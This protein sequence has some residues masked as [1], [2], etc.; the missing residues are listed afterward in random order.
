LGLSENSQRW[1]HVAFNEVPKQWASE[2][3]N[4]KNNEYFIALRRNFTESGMVNELVVN[5]ASFSAP[6][7]AAAL[8]AAFSPNDI[9]DIVYLYGVSPGQPQMPF[10]RADYYVRRPA[11]VPLTCAPNTGTLYKSAINQDG[12]ST[13]LPLLDCVAD[14][15]IVLGW[16]FDANGVVETW[17]S[18]E[19]TNLSTSLAGV[20]S[21]Y[22]S[23]ALKD[24]TT[25]RNQLK[26]IKVYVLAQD[27]LVD[28]SYSNT[29]DIVVGGTGEAN[30]TSTHTVAQINN[31]G[32]NNYRWRVYRLIV[33]PKNLVQPTQ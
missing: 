14:M 15:Q 17:S 32:W 10:N 12:S 20:D 22:I 28:R 24:A 1:N 9:N 18:P 7:N 27:G 25:I 26:V 4:L 21:V 6:Y 33:T 3:E 30:L 5:G 13:D 11:N 16:D 2:S 8:P 19:G 29:R 23:N 31:N